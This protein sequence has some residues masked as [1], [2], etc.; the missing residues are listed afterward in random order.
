MVN[1]PNLKVGSIVK[2]LVDNKDMGIKQGDILRVIKVG[3]SNWDSMDYADV[4]T[5]DGTTIEIM[6]NYRDFE[7]VP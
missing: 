3:R 4:I 2:I 6:N 5:K 1:V 7:L